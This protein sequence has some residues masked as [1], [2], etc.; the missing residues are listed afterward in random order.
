MVEA[1]EPENGF[2][3]H[4]PLYNLVTHPDQAGQIGFI[5]PLVGFPVLIDL[6]GRTE[7]DYGLDSVSAPIVHVLMFP[8]LAFELWGVPAD[9]VN[10]FYRFVTPLQ[11]FG[12]CGVL[13]ACGDGTVSGSARTPRPRPYLQNPTTCGVPLTFS[14]DLEYYTGTN[15]TPRPHGHRPAA[16][17]S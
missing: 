12:E 17:I 9:P 2:T 13:A 3:F 15:T 10:D 4:M 16:V 14:A 11:S 8:Q 5:F 1:G 6:S 7:S